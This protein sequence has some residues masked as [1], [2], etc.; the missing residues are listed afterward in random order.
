MCLLKI[1]TQHRRSCQQRCVQT[2]ARTRC[3]QYIRLPRA[4]TGQEQK[5]TPARQARHVINK[6]NPGVISVLVPQSYYLS[7][8]YLAPI[9]DI[10]NIITK[11]N[12]SFKNLFHCNWITLCTEQTSFTPQIED[13]IY[14]LA[15]FPTRGFSGLY[16]SQAGRATCYRKTE[17]LMIKV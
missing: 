17:F 12:E 11:M 4:G 8:L 3:C 13:P 9:Q 2:Q 16:S 6:N 14:T 5:G 1:L 10:K 7:Q 15:A